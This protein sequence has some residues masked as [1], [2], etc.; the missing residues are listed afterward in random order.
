MNSE[1]RAM[2]YVAKHLPCYECFSFDILEVQFLSYM[3][4]CHVIFIKQK[5]QKSVRS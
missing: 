2:L 1:L 3:I 4:D 5:E